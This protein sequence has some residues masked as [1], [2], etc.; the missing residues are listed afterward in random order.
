[1]MRQLHQLKMKPE[2]EEI[3]QTLKGTTQEHNCFQ[4]HVSKLMVQENSSLKSYYRRTEQ[5][6]LLLISSI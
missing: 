4:N 2:A 1:M 3:G 6:S 5:P